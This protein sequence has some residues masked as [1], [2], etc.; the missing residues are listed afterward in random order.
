MYFLSQ[1][2]AVDHRNLFVRNFRYDGTGPDAYFWVGDDKQ[3]SPKG[4]IVPYPPLSD[5]MTFNSFPTLR[6]TGSRRKGKTPK[7]PEPPTLKRMRNENVLLTLPGTLKVTEIR[8]LSI[9]CRRFTV[10]YG[11]VYIPPDLQIPKSVVSP[12]MIQQQTFVMKT[13]VTK[14]FAF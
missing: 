9:W 7:V 8:W 10:N 2:Y 13:F 12:S 3:P 6:R 5:S 4:I 14:N 11:E 1:V